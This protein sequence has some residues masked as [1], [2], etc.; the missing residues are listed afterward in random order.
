MVCKL[1][2]VFIVGGRGGGYGGGKQK[3]GGGR[4][5]GA[6][7]RRGGGGRGGRHPPGLTGPQIGM[8]YRNEANRDKIKREREQVCLANFG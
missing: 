2:H 8:W 1:G 7:R 5:G 6:G 4:G 3:R